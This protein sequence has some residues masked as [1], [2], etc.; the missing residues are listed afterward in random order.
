MSGGKG[1]CCLMPGL[2]Q[3]TEVFSLISFISPSSFTSLSISSRPIPK[4]KS[5]SGPISVH[6]H[7]SITVFKFPRPASPN[8]HHRMRAEFRQSNPASLNLFIYTPRPMPSTK[9]RR[10]S[11]PHL[12][13]IHSSRS[14]DGESK[15]RHRRTGVIHVLRCHSPF[16]F[17]SLIKPNVS[18]PRALSFK[19]SYSPD[20]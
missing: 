9:T 2:H 15:P 18:T 16:R 19:K 1:A 6:M 8:F 14:P 5:S 13:R 20:A 4:I 3:R 11:S 10:P 17:T 12:V 7:R